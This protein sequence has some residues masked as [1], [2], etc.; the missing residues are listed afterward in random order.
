LGKELVICGGNEILAK[1]RLLQRYGP[2]DLPPSAITKHADDIVDQFQ[3]EVYKV[4]EREDVGL[5]EATEIAARENPRLM[6][7]MR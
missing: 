6:K 3:D 4:C 5:L 1:Q 7:F 2:N